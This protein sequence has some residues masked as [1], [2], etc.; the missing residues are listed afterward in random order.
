[1]FSHI[2]RQKQGFTLIELIVV[3]S[4]VGLLSGVA[5]TV[6][7]ADSKKK[8]SEDSVKKTNIRTLAEGIESYRTAEG[9]YPIDTTPASMNPY[10]KTW[11]SG[12]NYVT[13]A[14]APYTNFYIY[15]R[16]SV[17]ASIFFKYSSLWKE[18]RECTSPTPGFGSC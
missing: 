15:I 9:Q 1:M 16:S 13:N 10:V 4:L 5:I 2:N 12:Y 8:L 18:I 6:I 17:N 7:N 14:V 11:P 3:V